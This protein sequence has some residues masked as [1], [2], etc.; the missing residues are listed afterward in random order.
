M[1]EVSIAV[2]AL[3]GVALLLAVLSGGGYP[4]GPDECLAAG[5][6]YCEQPGGGAV[7]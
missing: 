7:A 3:A 4:G 6:C 1:R 2:V 5:D